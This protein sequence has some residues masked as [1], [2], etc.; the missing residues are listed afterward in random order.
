MGRRAKV[1]AA[2]VDGAAEI[3]TPA[4]L[5]LVVDLHDRFAIRREHLLAER[6]RRQDM[7]AVGEPLDFLPET[8]AIRAGGWRVT[9]PA[10][11]PP[12]RPVLDLADGTSPTWPNLL[13]AQRSAVDQP[14]L[15]RPRG[16]HLSEKHLTIDGVPAVATFVDVGLLLARLGPDAPHPR[17]SLPM[18]ES[19]LEARLWADLL[20]WVEGALGRP[21]GWVTVTVP[22]E[23]IW[24]AFEMDEVLYELRD[25]AVGLP[26]ARCAY[27]FSLVKTFRGAGTDYVLPQWDALDDSAPFLHA[28]AALVAATA[29]RR[30]LG[31]PGSG[32][33]VTGKDLLDI[34]SV[35]LTV[36]LDGLR[37]TVEVA[38]EFLVNWLAGSAAV[39]ID[40]RPV[41]LAT[42][43]LCRS[44]LWQWRRNRASLEGGR[45]ITGYLVVAELDEA[46]ERLADRWAERPGGR[47]LLAGARNL[48]YDASTAL[49]FTDFIAVPAYELMP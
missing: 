32:V 2:P 38:L 10:P 30:G 15:L 26:I 46:T 8:A 11:D 21:A 44:Q 4:A 41:D 34:R 35:P 23:T 37:S 16:L 36:T 7:V 39:T 25:R 45:R 40:G 43:E 3:L 22:V 31:G 33:P 19:H 12:D 5:A 9:A 6:Q 24:V 1:L 18:L 28:Y 29:E 20:T 49:R 13:A 14:V 48:L 47:E 17:L 42:A 27:L